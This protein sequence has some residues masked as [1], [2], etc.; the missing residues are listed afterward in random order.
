MDHRF[1]QDRTVRITNR[2]LSLLEL[3]QNGPRHCCVAAGRARRI[4]SAPPLPDQP[5]SLRHLL[6]HTSGLP[7]YTGLPD[8]HAAVSAQAPP[9]PLADMLKRAMKQGMSFAP[10]QGWS[11]SNIGYAFVANLIEATTGLPLDKALKMHLLDPLGLTDA[12]L[13]QT[14]EAFAT[15]H[16]PEAAHYHPGWVYH[17]CLT[18]TAKEAA[19]LVHG[20]FSGCLLEPATLDTMRIARPL[21]GAL[22]G[23]PWTTHGYALGLMRGAVVGAVGTAIGHSGAGPFSVNAVYHFPD[24]SDPATVA[25]FTNG[26]DEGVA[27]NEAVRLAQNLT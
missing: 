3:D 5:Y 24:M 1:G 16:W 27:E 12:T 19:L 10:G 6:A 25:V 9:W 20:L 26:T 18:G 15:L 11:Y 8:Y 17:R 22:P 2:A 13:D 21:G 23:R 4:G 14:Q 7:D